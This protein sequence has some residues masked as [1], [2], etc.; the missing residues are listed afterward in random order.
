MRKVT[1][2]KQELQ[3]NAKNAV[4][5]FAT[6]LKN[7]LCPIAN[8]CWKEFYKYTASV[9][10]VD[11]A[12]IG[13]GI[14]GNSDGMY[15]FEGN[16]DDVIGIFLPRL[17]G[18]YEDYYFDICELYEEDNNVY[19]ETIPNFVD[20]YYDGKHT[21]TA[22]FVCDLDGLPKCCYESAKRV[23]TELVEMLSYM[24][25]FKK[26]EYIEGGNDIYENSAEENSIRFVGVK[27]C[28]DINND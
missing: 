25:G 22:A 10:W 1:I 17:T 6:E 14:Y 26:I 7:S 18:A 28:F 12:D 23:A 16:N 2:Q 27:F 13:N 5:K 9:Y 11:S 15:L 4:K 20:I 19:Q 3:Q 21:I 8:A 24:K